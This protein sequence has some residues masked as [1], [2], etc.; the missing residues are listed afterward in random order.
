MSISHRD[1]SFVRFADHGASNGMLGKYTRRLLL[2]ALLLGVVAI[3][4]LWPQ[5]PDGGDQASRLPSADL[6]DRGSAAAPG[7]ADATVASAGMHASERVATKKFERARDAGAASV[8]LQVTAPSAVQAGE[9]FHAWIHVEAYGGLR[10]LAFTVRYEKALLSLVDRS[11]GDFA[12]LGGIPAEWV[13][14][15]P[16]DGNVEVSF[17]V[18]NGLAVAAAGSIAVLEFEALKPGASTIRLQNVTAIDPTGA[19]ERA[20]AVTPEAAVAIR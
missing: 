7:R 12:R 18:R 20:A 10:E 8:R 4:R 11:E 19:K 2:A 6:A 13:A 1:I 15:E 14:N 5:E 16:S 17:K 3:V 9:V